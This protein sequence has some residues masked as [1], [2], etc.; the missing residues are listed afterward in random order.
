ML[1][2]LLFKQIDNSALIVFRVF[3]GLLI[4]LESFG[5]IATGW[6]KVTLIEPK[7][8]FT[9][10]G[11]E[12]L[13]PL[14]GPWMYVYYSIMG[15]CGIGVLLG[16]RYR[17]SIITFT[18]L[19][20]ATYFMQKSAYNN[21]YYLMIY[22]SAFMALVPANTYLSLD[23]KRNPA[24]AKITMPQWCSLIF[25]IQMWIVYTYASV[26]K[27]YPD[28]ID[29]TVIELMMK[30]KQNYFLVGE[31]LQQKWF[32][33]V[34]SYSGILFDL[35]VVPMLLWKPTR[36]MAFIASLF[37]HLFNS[38]V[39]Q[40]GVF[41]YMSLALCVFFFPAR[42][43]RDIFLRKKEFYEGS[44]I[45]IPSRNRFIGYALMSYFIVQIILPLRHWIIK[46]DVLWTEE[47]HRLSWRMML[48][49]RQGIVKYKVKNKANGKIKEI[50]LQDHLSRK[51]RGNVATKPDMIWQF[52]QY[53]KE[54]Y[55]NDH[56]MDVEV[57]VDCRVSVN[58]KPFQ[59][60]IDPNIDLSSIKWDAFRHSD[61]IL[62]SKQD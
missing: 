59:Q 35:L 38:A 14:P 45:V 34:I 20:A 28:W 26:A 12:W 30:A 49:L 60:F 61:W 37:F 1:N 39:F 15:I 42:T 52:S 25:V 16:Y 31:F 43:I 7:F 44:D 48:R 24:I 57:Y 2:R 36:K 29:T 53:L 62:P 32:H 56:N 55:K 3:F 4:T 46:D 6:V 17:T 13:Q 11:F 51:Q 22:L 50:R 27:M 5:A 54:Y 47:G 9:F 19:W 41:P 8:T 40:V 33:Y 58:G 10:I 21:H 23:A 18:V